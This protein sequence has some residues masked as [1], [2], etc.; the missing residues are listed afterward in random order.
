MPAKLL[1]IQQ[2]GLLL[3]GYV[4]TIVYLPLTNYKRPHIEIP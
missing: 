1:I 4:Q 2:V 3:W